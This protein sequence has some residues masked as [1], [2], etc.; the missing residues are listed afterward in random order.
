MV[1]KSSKQLWQETV[2]FL[3]QHGLDTTGRPVKFVNKDQR[4]FECRMV[5]VPTNGQNGRHR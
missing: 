3:R 5:R 2:K 4:A 1:Q